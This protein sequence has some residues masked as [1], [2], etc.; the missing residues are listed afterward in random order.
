MVSEELGYVEKVSLAYCINHPTMISMRH[1][2]K[3]KIQGIG[4]MF[5]M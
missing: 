3:D 5:Y 4:E 1:F 2:S